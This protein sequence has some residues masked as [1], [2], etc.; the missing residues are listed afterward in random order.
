ML[1]Q[2]T[3][4]LTKWE[5]FKL[6]RLRMPWILLALAV[7]VSQLGI[8]VNYLAYH[9]DTVQE[10]V[11]GG[12]VSYSISFD[13]DQKISATM[14]CADFASDRFPSGFDQLTESQREHFLREGGS[15]ARR[16]GV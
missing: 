9:N 6:R 7:L 12:T 2:Q 10:V 14:T 15:M 13:E 5:W 1:M 4:R 16:G 3:L 11:S 8:W